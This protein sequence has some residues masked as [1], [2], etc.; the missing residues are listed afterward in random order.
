[1]SMKIEKIGKKHYIS[2]GGIMTE[3]SLAELENIKNHLEYYINN[4]SIDEI[5]IKLG[6]E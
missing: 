4:D 6:D 1:M 3:C 5:S 2:L